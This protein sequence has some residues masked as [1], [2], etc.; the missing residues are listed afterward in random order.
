MLS[1]VLVQLAATTIAGMVAGLLWGMSALIS[2]L[3]GGLCCAVPTGL[4]VLRL[5]VNAQK[6]AANPMNFFIGE[7]IKVALTIALMG[8]VVLFYSDLNWLA[9][10]AAILVVMKSYLILLF[11]H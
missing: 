4:L 10:L 1:I 9:F 3:L 2:A 5:F 11:R 6:S 7:F 8:A